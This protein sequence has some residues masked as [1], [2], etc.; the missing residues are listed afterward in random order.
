MSR[1]CSW[2]R[3]FLIKYIFLCLLGGKS[4]YGGKGYYMRRG[5]SYYKK[6]EIWLYSGISPG[7]KLLYSQFSGGKG[8]YIASFPGGGNLARGKGYYTIPSPICVSAFLGPP[9]PHPLLQHSPD[10][11]A[12]VHCRRDTCR[13]PSAYRRFSGSLAA[14]MRPYQP[15]P[16]LKRRDNKYKE[17]DGNDVTG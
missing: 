16:P 17:P 12:P 7:E 2:W 15:I 14:E 4:G 10:R 5:K 9:H 1:V 6:G 11:G 8:Y 3:W 13:R